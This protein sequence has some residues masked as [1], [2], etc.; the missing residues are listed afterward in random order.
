[1]I[2]TRQLAPN[3]L[4][5]VMD[6]VRKRSEETAYHLDPTQTTHERYEFIFT[7]WYLPGISH[8]LFGSFNEGRLVSIGGMRLAMP[9]PDAWALSNLK[10]DPDIPLHENG[11]GGLMRAIYIAGKQRGKVEYYTCMLKQRYKL[12]HRYLNRL[13]PTEFSAYER[14]IEVEIS[15]GTVPNCD[16]WWGMMGRQISSYDL[17]IT[18]SRLKG[19]PLA[20]SRMREFK[21]AGPGE[22]MVPP[23][24]HKYRVR[25]AILNGVYSET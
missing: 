16:L 15:A 25:T 7:K 9:I 3:D 11:M 23:A 5:G 10:T 4:G 13:V 2:V 21:D 14:W 1:M 18:R 6:L 22:S 19:Y 20:P 8:K 24:W 12:F 17:I